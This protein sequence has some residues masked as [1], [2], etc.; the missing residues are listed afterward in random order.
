LGLPDSTCSL[1]RSDRRIYVVFQEE[2]VDLNLI[3]H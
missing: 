2:N 3:E 1:C